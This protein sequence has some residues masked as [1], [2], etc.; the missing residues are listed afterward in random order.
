MN[1]WARRTAGILFIL[2]LLV[3]F[4]FSYASLYDLL[5]KVATIS[6]WLVLIFACEKFWN[7]LIDE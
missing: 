4:M 7:Y 2:V 3:A 6:L 5:G 1:V